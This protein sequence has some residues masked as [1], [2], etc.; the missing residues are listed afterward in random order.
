V[1]VIMPFLESL[2]WLFDDVIAPTCKKHGFCALRADSVLHQQNILRDIV[3]GLVECD[4]VLADITGLNPNV[5]YELG[6]AHGLQRPTI[7]LSQDLSTIP[8]D[9]R[10]YRALSYGEHYP[11]VLR[12]IESLNT[13]LPQIHRGEISFG[14][15]VSDFSPTHHS[16]PEPPAQVGP[17]D[18]L[19]IISKEPLEMGLLDFQHEVMDAT[20]V[21]T[22]WAE[23]IAGY[24]D[25]FATDLNA[26]TERLKSITD[27]DPQAFKKRRAIVASA[28]QL[29]NQWSDRMASELPTANDAWQRLER[30]TDGYLSG[31]TITSEQDIAAASSLVEQIDYFIGSIDGAIVAIEEAANSTTSLRKVSRSLGQSATRTQRVLNEVLEVLKMGKAYGARVISVVSSRREEESQTA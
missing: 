13:L 19:S 3:E 30:T 12:L 1:F 11:D 9:L 24:A 18:S 2:N 14:N 27:G 4:L 26:R 25:E 31:L 21:V 5:M 16:V 17:T 10:G 7:L 8:F 6:L 23:N 28:A 22:E 15:P 20:E 29:L